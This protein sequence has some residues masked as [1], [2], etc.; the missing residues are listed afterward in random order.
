MKRPLALLG[1]IAAAASLAACGSPADGDA[2]AGP[3]QSGGVLRYG[4]SQAPSC[5]DPAQSGSNQTIYVTRQIVDSLTDQD[6]TTGEL[7]PW[8]ADSW[9]VAPDAR[10]FTFH[11]REGVTFSDGSALTPETIV[12]NFDAIVQRLGA[13]KAS[14]AASYLSGYRGGTVVDPRTVRIDF[15]QP[16]AQFLQATS[17]PQLGIVSDATTAKSPEERC[18]TTPIG[19]GPFTY[20]DWKQGASVTLA[21]RSGYAW[22]SAVFTRS[23]EAYLDRIDFTVVP[24]TGVRVGSLASGQ[25]DVISDA[26]PENAPQIEGAGGKLLTV[27]NPGLPFGLQ[28]NVTRGVLG[29]PVIRRALGIAI[30]RRELVETVLGPQFNPATSA[31]ASTTPGYVDHSKQLGFDRSAATEL[32]EGAGWLPGPDGI[33]VKNGQ[34]LSFAVLY[35][36]VFAGNQAVLELAQQQLRKAGIEITLDLQ[37][38]AIALARQKAHDFDVTYYNTTRAD[39]DILRTVFALDQQN[40]NSRGP[41]APLDAA[42]SL[43]LASVDTGARRTALGQAQQLILDNGLWIPVVEL[44]QVIG[45]AGTTHEV[46]FE[47]SGRLQLHDTWVRG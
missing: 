28:P 14:L 36:P 16:N 4:L 45:V 6:P 34:R 30:D 18:S 9:Q 1:V 32:L 22:G 43:Q 23:G 31:L 17:T 19:S 33:R 44:S 27:V 12:K 5:P 46:K 10:S 3:P 47:A 29:D 37:P 20:A 25:L 15:D 7:E 26:L 39:G 2:D 8:L 21:K 38:A 35:S 24:E 13:V 42:L 11:L 41:I 40:Y